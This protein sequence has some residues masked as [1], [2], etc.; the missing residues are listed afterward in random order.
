MD[1]LSLNRG[2][3]QLAW[4]GK[5]E[6]RDLIFSFSNA[7]ISNFLSSEL[8]VDFIDLPIPSHIHFYKI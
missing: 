6:V 5:S 8:T 1:G 2:N 7:A 4:W 3:L